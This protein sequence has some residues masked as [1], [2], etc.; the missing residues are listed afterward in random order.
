MPY[1]EAR[2][3]IK[4]KEF[5][6]SVDVDEALKIKSGKGGSVASA[7][8]SPEIYFDLKKG[9]RA[10]A[11]E[12]DNY[13]GSKDIYKIAE[14]I[15]KEGEVQKPQEYRDAEREA[16]IK[17]VIDLVLRNAVDQHGKPYTE[18]RIRRAVAEVH[19]NFDNRP[20]E[21]QMNELVDKLKTVIPIKVELK[22]IKLIIPARFTGQVYGIISDIK[23]SEEWL[24]NG[25]LQAIVAIPAGMQMDFYDK[26]NGITHGAV[27]SEEVKD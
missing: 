15:I 5:Q 10:S 24:S 19:F 12:L 18:E 22:K 20:A 4:G 14:R 6:I 8:N 9:M 3:K 11:N 2:L 25:D 17:R 13:F 27:M 7:L 1:V 16:R 21:Q 26:L 23:I